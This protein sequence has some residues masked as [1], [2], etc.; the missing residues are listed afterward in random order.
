M[1]KSKNHTFCFSWLKKAMEGLF[2]QP[3]GEVFA[4]SEPALVAGRRLK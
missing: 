2:Q 4:L 1:K 3:V